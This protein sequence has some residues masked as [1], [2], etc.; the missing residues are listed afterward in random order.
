MTARIRPQLH[1]YAQSQPPDVAHG[2]VDHT[3]TRVHPSEVSRCLRHSEYGEY[4]WCHE[5][6]RALLDHRRF[7]VIAILLFVKLASDIMI[8][9]DS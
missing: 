9:H 5:C 4:I 1:G 8:V 6:F 3:S 7:T 2:K